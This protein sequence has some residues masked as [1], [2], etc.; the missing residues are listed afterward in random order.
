MLVWR[1][2]G[3]VPGLDPLE[4]RLGQ[5]VFGFPPRGVEEFALHRRP[6]RFDHRVVPG[7]Q[8]RSIPLVISELSG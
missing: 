4:D 6:E 2:R 8:M 5:L 3:F 7:R 1:R